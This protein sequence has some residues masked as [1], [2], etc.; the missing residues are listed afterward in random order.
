[1]IDRTWQEEPDD[2]S[3]DVAAWTLHLDDGRLYRA[4]RARLVRPGGAER[5]RLQH[6]EDVWSGPTGQVRWYRSFDDVK[7]A[8]DELEAQR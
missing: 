7:R 3:S 5:W 4:T 1:M 8:V 2:P 6:H